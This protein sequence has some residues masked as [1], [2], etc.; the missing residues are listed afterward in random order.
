MRLSRSL[1]FHTRIEPQYAALFE[2]EELGDIVRN[3]QR[4]PPIERPPITN[5]DLRTSA[6]ARI[7]YDQ[8]RSQWQRAVGRDV[9]LL[10]SVA[11]CDH[12][13][14]LRGKRTKQDEKRSRAH[15]HHEDF[16]NQ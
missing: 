6:I 1:L 12:W 3:I 2:S 13:F 4:T 15:A 5:D 8:H 7:G 11:G 14:G 9:R 16:Q 10:R